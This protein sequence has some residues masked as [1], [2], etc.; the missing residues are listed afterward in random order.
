MTTGNVD[1]SHDIHKYV[2]FKS[3]WD[4]VPVGSKVKRPCIKVRYMYMYVKVYLHE[5]TIIYMDELLFWYGL[6]IIMYT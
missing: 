1:F 6:R 4:W 3:L 5:Y 2:P